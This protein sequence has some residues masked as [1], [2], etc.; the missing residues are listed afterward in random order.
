MIKTKEQIADRI[1]R[2]RKDIVKNKIRSQYHNNIVSVVNHEIWFKDKEIFNY[3]LEKYFRRFVFRS[4]KEK[5]NY[6]AYVNGG[7]RILS[8]I[9]RLLPTNRSVE[10]DTHIIPNDLFLINFDFDKEKFLNDN[11][12]NLN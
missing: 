1:E 4:P 11:N 8:C 3:N 10:L 12:G 7:K 5:H 6:I 2:I 9:W